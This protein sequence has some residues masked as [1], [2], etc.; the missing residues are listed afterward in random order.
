MIKFLTAIKVPS[1]LALSAHSAWREALIQHS[2]NREFA[3]T[4]GPQD[5]CAHP[6]AL[7]CLLQFMSQVLD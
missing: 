5:S 2:V 3:T 4:P 7:V 6:K 1:R